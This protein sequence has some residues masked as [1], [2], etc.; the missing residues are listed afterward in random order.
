MDHTVRYVI[1]KL[2][3]LALAF[4]PPTDTSTSHPVVSLIEKSFLISC[5]NIGRFF[6]VMGRVRR[7]HVNIGLV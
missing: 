7:Q 1:T 3:K 6:N 2:Y 4:I 5:S